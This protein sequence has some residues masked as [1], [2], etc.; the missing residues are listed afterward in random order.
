MLIGTADEHGSTRIHSTVG[1]NHEWTR[2]DTNT[3]GFIWGF[4]EGVQFLPPA[5]AL[6]RREKEILLS[7]EQ[8]KQ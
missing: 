7:S 2:M 6:R 3:E 1:K 4:K 8:K 5:E